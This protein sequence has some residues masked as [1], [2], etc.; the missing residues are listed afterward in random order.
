VV[1]V[2]ANT[3]SA[4]IGRRGT[5]RSSG[6]LFCCRRRRNRHEIRIGAV[7]RN[8]DTLAAPRMNDLVL[9]VIAGSADSHLVSGRSRVVAPRF[10]RAA[11][12]SPPGFDVLRCSG[13]G[14]GERDTTCAS[15]LAQ[16]PGPAGGNIPFYEVSRSRVGNPVT[17]LGRGLSR[18]WTGCSLWREGYHRWM[19]TRPEN[20]V[21]L[22]FRSRS[23]PSRGVLL[24]VCEFCLRRHSACQNVVDCVGD[25]RRTRWQYDLQSRDPF[26]E[27]WT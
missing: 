14:V 13:V 23:P 21:T 1:T 22:R 12:E 24:D 27:W 19:I 18:I 10:R 5:P 26:S 2:E 11:G 9:P 15:S 4:R 7:V 16:M 17:G 6:Q 25:V 8:C 3:I 20:C